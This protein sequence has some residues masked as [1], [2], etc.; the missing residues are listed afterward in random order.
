MTGSGGEE[1]PKIKKAK[2]LEQQRQ[3]KEKFKKI[4]AAKLAL[5]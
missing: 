3:D 5:V 4:Q 1:D 2:M